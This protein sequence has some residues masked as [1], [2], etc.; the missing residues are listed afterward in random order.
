MEEKF[1]GVWGHLREVYIQMKKPELYKK[2]RLSGFWQRR[3]FKKK[4]MTRWKRKFSS[5]KKI[6]S[7]PKG[8][9]PIFYVKELELSNGLL[10]D[11]ILKKKESAP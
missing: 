10:Y 5:N 3:K 9:I 11:K 2:I 6:W 4:F 8:T 7:F 1:C